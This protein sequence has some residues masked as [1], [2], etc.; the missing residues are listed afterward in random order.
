MLQI[1]A[2]GASGG[3]NSQKNVRGGKGAKGIAYFNLTRGDELDVVI[4][5][6]GQVRI[7]RTSETN[8]GSGGGGGTFVYMRGAALPLLALGGGG[9]ASYSSYFG[10]SGLSTSSGGRANPS[11]GEGGQLGMGGRGSGR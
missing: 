11:G 8:Y 6:A 4:G 2:A 1:I 5:Q 10:G 7:G 9:G 3:G